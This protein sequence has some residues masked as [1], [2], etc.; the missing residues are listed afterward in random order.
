MAIQSK[1]DV[2]ECGSIYLRI[3]FIV[4][5]LGAETWN[6][7]ISIHALSAQNAQA[8]MSSIRLLRLISCSLAKILSPPGSRKDIAMHR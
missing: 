5:L 2:A 3:R 7:S 8:N 6:A 4:I 1:L